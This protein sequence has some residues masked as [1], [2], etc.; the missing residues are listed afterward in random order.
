MKMAEF[1]W[2]LVVAVNSDEVLKSNLLLSGEGNLSKEVVIRRHSI[3]AGAAYNDG[4]AETTGEVVVFAHQDVYLPAGWSKKLSQVIERLTAQDPEWGLAGVYG[5]TVSGSGAGFVY[6]IGLRHFVGDPFTEAIRVRSLDEMLLIM[7]RS[8]NL[9]FDERLPGFHLY[10]TDICLEAEARGMN[11]YVVPAFAVHNSCGIKWLPLSFWQ[12]YMYLRKKWADRLP[13]TTP[14]TK[15]TKGCTPIIEYFLTNLLAM[16]RN[17]KELGS[18]VPDPGK[19]Y[20]E[21]LAPAIER[22]TC[23]TVGK[24]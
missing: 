1:T 16:V 22:K 6:S 8:S 21:H 3:S 18:R 4:L 5:T 19:F 2:S 11:N 24:G 14:C 9:C 15:I 7:R 12:A 23:G 17:K 13:V 10:G 20:S